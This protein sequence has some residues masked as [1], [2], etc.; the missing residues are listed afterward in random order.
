MVYW[1]IFSFFRN[2]KGVFSVSKFKKELG[3]CGILVAG[4][5][6]PDDYLNHL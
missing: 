6:G 5:E 3:A 2:V 1:D 4:E